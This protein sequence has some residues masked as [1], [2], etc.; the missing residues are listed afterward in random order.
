MVTVYVIVYDCYTSKDSY[1][2]MFSIMIDNITTHEMVTNALFQ[3]ILRL[4]LIVFTITMPVNRS[5]DLD[6]T[7]FSHRHYFML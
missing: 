4:K 5:I 2:T 1:Q 7:M 6:Y 3:S